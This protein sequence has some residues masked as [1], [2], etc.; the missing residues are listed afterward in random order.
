MP[1]VPD[2]AEAEDLTASA[3]DAQAVKSE[4]DPLATATDA[5]P[6]SWWV[7]GMDERFAEVLYLVDSQTMPMPNYY[8]DRLAFGSIECEVRFPGISKAQM[9]TEA[10]DYI[11]A[12]LAP[13]G[14]IIA[15]WK[16][17]RA[18]TAKVRPP[19]ELRPKR[20]PNIGANGKVWVGEGN[21]PLYTTEDGRLIGAEAEFPTPISAGGSGSSYAA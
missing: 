15:H 17:L 14:S 7:Q 8:A 16:K 9:L 1:F 2:Q 4:D 6:P 20:R 13:G 12:Q 18:H 3:A 19:D 21:Q 10:A 5:K 11:D